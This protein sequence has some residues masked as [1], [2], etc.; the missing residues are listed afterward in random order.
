MV[1]EVAGGEGEQMD[2]AIFRARRKA[3]ALGLDGNIGEI[4]SAPTE[5]EADDRM[6][7]LDAMG[8]PKQ[9]VMYLVARIF[10]VDPSV[11]A[12]AQKELGPIIAGWGLPETFIPWY[13]TFGEGANVRFNFDY[14]D[15]SDSLIK[16]DRARQRLFN[17]AVLDFSFKAVRE[18]LLR[19]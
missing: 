5:E 3:E 14:G 17:D 1:N 16:I 11:Q 15:K 4:L 7:R 2:P 9:L 12:A 8:G 10:E 13:L 19:E 6:H 18:Y